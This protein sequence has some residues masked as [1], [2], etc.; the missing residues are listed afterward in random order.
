MIK[1]KPAANLFLY[2]QKCSFSTINSQLYKSFAKTILN[3]TATDSTNLGVLRYL[4][5]LKGRDNSFTPQSLLLFTTINN[6]VK[7]VDESIEISNRYPNLQ[8][9]SGVVDTIPVNNKT[10]SN[11]DTT[12]YND[13]VSMMITDQSIT[14]NDLKP[15]EDLDNQDQLIRDNNMEH[16]GIYPVFGRSNW[17]S[18]DSEIKIYFEDNQVEGPRAVLKVP[19]ASTLFTELQEPSTLFY[20]TG[21]NNQTNQIDN[22]NIINDQRSSRN[23]IKLKE[24]ENDLGSKLISNLSTKIIKHS[25]EF[26]SSLSITLPLS[27]DSIQKNNKLEKITPFLKITSCKQN[28]VKTINDGPASYYLEEN[29]IIKKLASKETR[30]F[31]HIKQQ[32]GDTSDEELQFEVIAGGGGWGVKAGILALSPEAKIRPGMFAS[33]SII[34]PESN[35]KVISKRNYTEENQTNVTD[36]DINNED[37]VCAHTDETASAASVQTTTYQSVG[38][39]AGKKEEESEISL[40]LCVESSRQ[41]TNY[42]NL[43]ASEVPNIIAQGIRHE[44][45]KGTISTTTTASNVVEIDG[46]LAL[47]SEKGYFINESRHNSPGETGIFIL[48]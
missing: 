7:L 35:V 22:N 36:D 37:L 11:N 33:F 19:V 20:I 43:Q 24:G 47:G 32:E 4:E 29:D 14:I 6:S 21:K 12:S 38:K 23:E 18:F 15:I 44:E 9:I 10:T 16:R 3:P 17:K 2:Q 48:S 45:G 25:G 34:R 28:L 39:S 42:A 46:L 41:E 26:L 31:V 13:A 30:V 40:R 27:I 8:I 5:Q 1:F